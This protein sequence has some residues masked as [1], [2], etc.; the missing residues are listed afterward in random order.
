MLTSC[1]IV[2]RPLATLPLARSIMP[3]FCATSVR[4]A[5]SFMSGVVDISM[6][7]M[8]RRSSLYVAFPSPELTMPALSSSTAI[9][10]M[11]IDPRELSRW[12]FMATMDVLWKPE[13]LLPSMTILRITWTSLTGVAL[14]WSA[15]SRTVFSASW[16]RGAGGSSS[17]ST[18][19]LFDAKAWYSNCLSLANSA[20]EAWSTSPS[21][22][23]TGCSLRLIENMGCSSSLM[24]QPQSQKSFLPSSLWW[25]SIPIFILSLP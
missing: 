20:W 9:S 6:S 19:Q 8:P 12:P 4:W 15:I 1:L 3:I 21:S 17:I 24:A 5:P 14:S 11:P 25:I 18:R 10:G 2:P 16:F 22:L 23:K 7:G 13:V